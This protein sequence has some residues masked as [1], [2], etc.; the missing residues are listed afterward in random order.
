MLAAPAVAAEDQFR[1]R[2]DHAALAGLAATQGIERPGPGESVS[3]LHRDRDQRLPHEGLGKIPLR[4]EFNPALVFI[5]KG[6]GGG[7]HAVEL[8]YRGENCPADI[9]QCRHRIQPDSEVPFELLDGL[10]L[11]PRGD[12]PIHDTD[13]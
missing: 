6:E 5:D 2:F 10:L 13:G 1:L 11:L 4:G 12:I 9:F 8:N 3:D 7:I